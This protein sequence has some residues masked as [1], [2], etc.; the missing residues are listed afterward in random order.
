[1]SWYH[2]SLNGKSWWHRA[3]EE[4]ILTILEKNIPANSTIFDIGCGDGSST[5][6]IAKRYNY[7]GFE[8]EEESVKKAIKKGLN[9]EKIDD[10]LTIT[11]KPDAILMLDVLEHIKED[12]LMLKKISK[13]LTKG[14]KVVITVPAFQ[15]LRSYHDMDMKHYSRYGA[16]EI[17]KLCEGSGI[18][19]KV[20]SHWNF[21]L[22]IPIL[23]LRKI[24]NLVK[25]SNEKRISQERFIHRNLDPLLLRVLRFENWL[26]KKGI[27]LPFGV[28]IVLVGESEV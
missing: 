9:V 10:S 22:F 3:R 6:R 26:I 7:K 21:F 19:V 15:I 24:Q 4:L 25:I 20:I 28:S 8:I 13:L 18:K 27:S 5:E 2:S 14:G 12:N 23:I 11:G 1:M 17:K 16:D